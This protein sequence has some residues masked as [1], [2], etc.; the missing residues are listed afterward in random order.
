MSG[1]VTKNSIWF[2]Q[3]YFLMKK[4]QSEEDIEA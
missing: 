4:K 1:S 3:K 2:D